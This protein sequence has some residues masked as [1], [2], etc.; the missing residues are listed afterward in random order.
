MTLTT[1]VA[2]VLGILCSFLFILL[3][4]RA[5]IRNIEKIQTSVQ[6]I[7]EDRLVVKGLI[8]KLS[9]L[10]HRKQIANLTGDETFYPH[11]NEAINAQIDEHLR[12]FRATQLTPDEAETLQIFSKRIQELQAREKQFGLSKA[13]SFAP[14]SVKAL[15]NQLQGLHENLK[16]LSDIQLSEG[17]RKL[18]I[19]DK[20]SGSIKTF[21]RI[22]NY[23]LITFA[24]LALIIIFVIPTKQQEQP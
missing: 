6:E 21:A 12:A 13:P 17:K 11:T 18:L 5:N 8:F 2:L 14:S 15:S 1:K 9:S 19:S 20:A 16:T 4:G 23:M 24:V 3:T 7:Y 22:E 10:L